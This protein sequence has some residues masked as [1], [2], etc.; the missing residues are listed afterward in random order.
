MSYLQSFIFIYFDVP[1]TSFLPTEGVWVWQDGSRMSLPTD[2]WHDWYPGQPDNVDQREHC[3]ILTN[4]KFWIL[5]GY[6]IERYLWLDYS[7]DVNTEN[8]VTGYICEGTVKTIV[9]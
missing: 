9:K 1:L 7:C 4:L 5:Q 8:Q 3:A 6:R 2:T